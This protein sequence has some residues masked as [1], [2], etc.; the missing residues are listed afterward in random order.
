MFWK[1]AKI[2]LSL[3]INFANK[4][5]IRDDSSLNENKLV[6][7]VTIYRV[8]TPICS[9]RSFSIGTLKTFHKLRTYLRIMIETNRRKTRMET[10][11]DAGGWFNA[12]IRLRSCLQCTCCL[13]SNAFRNM[14][15]YF[16]IVWC[17]DTGKCTICTAK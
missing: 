13:W 7:D 8:D 3:S 16:I 1:H 10:I 11:F 14:Y 6:I 17:I 2:G 5:V 15:S 9:I 12:N 4:W